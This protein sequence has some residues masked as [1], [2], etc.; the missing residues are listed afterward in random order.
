M[1]SLSSGR[2]LEYALSRIEQSPA[3]CRLYA[4]SLLAVLVGAC[5]GENDY[6]GFDASIDASD[7][8]AFL[9][10]FNQQADLGGGDYVLIAATNGAGLSGDFS[11]TI[12]PG[13][14][15]VTVIVRS[16]QPPKRA[17]HTTAD[18]TLRFI[19]R[20]RPWARSTAR[21]S[22]SPRA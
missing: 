18:A 19:A 3:F 20:P 13:G 1:T 7:P 15:L 4:L 22:V 9:K 6:N 8:D 5:G 2:L 11:V 21:E 16:R 14:S 17:A 12:A 10:F